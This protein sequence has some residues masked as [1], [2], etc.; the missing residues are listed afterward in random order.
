MDRGGLEVLSVARMARADSA[1][2]AAGTP[3]VAL[4]EHAAAA[5]ARAV[6][7]RWTPRPTLV[8]CGPGNNGGDGF[9]AAALLA[10]AGWPVT[11]ALLGDRAALRGDA[12]V[13]AA[14]WGGPVRGLDPAAVADAALVVDALFGAG[15]SRPVEGAAAAMLEAVAASGVPGAPGVPVVAVDV[16]SGVDGD[17]GAVSGTAAPARVTVTFCRPKPAHLL[18]PGRALCGEVEL[19]D[20]GIDP[21]TVAAVG[22]DARVNGPA[23]WRDRLPLPAPDTH[24]YRRGHAVVA[25]GA[26]LTGAARLAARAAL[27]VGAGLVTVAAPEAAL[28][29][30]RASSSSVMARP[31]SD[32]PDLLADPRVTAALVGP[33]NGV[34]ADTRARALA[35]LAAGKPAALDADALTSFADDPAALFGALPGRPCVLTPHDGEYARLFG[36]LARADG[37]RLTRA[38]AAAGAS[39]AVVL[40]KGPETVVAEPGG[41]AVIGVDGPPDLATAGTGD[42]LAGVVAG[43]LAAGAAPFDAACMAAWLHGAAATEVGRGLIAEDLPDRIPAA[44]ARATR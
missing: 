12:A 4:M 42:V 40:L 13:M 28:P 10:D 17:S 9:G 20:I 29:V 41:R 6:R 36:G 22:H 23:L 27:R 16:P 7:R 32:W 1:T 44:L 25:G 31:L 24:K 33:G 19:A 5:V 21:A 37:D 43:L 34:G 11:V 3:G 15:L 35:T 26:R 39:G 18:T 8:L 14:R 2:I 38:R 30:H